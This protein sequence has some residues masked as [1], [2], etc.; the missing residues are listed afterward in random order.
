MDPAPH[1]AA[2][3]SVGADVL[4]ALGAFL[5]PCFH[6]PARLLEIQGSLFVGGLP[7]GD[8][9]PPPSPIMVVPAR[10]GSPVPTVLQDRGGAG[11][12]TSAQGG[13]TVWPHGGAP[14]GQNKCVSRT[15]AERPGGTGCGR[16]DRA[17]GGGD[18]TLP[19]PPGA[20]QPSSQDTDKASWPR[21][22]RTPRRKP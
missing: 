9:A 7:T 20:G 17:H 2:L 4:P 13:Q 6:F 22:A 14:A 11:G 3:A 8:L 12:S 15:A 1:W 16:K 18:R 10:K 19:R 21:G 5:V